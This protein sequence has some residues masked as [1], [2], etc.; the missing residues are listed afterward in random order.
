MLVG[1]SYAT[2]SKYP[3]F[4]RAA[5]AGA[6]SRAAEQLRVAQPALS[7]YIR[8]LEQ[9]VGVLLFERNGRGVS[10][11][12]DGQ[13]LYRFAKSVFDKL[14]AAELEVANPSGPPLTTVKLGIVPSMTEVLAVPLAEAVRQQMPRVGLHVSEGQNSSLLRWLDQGVIDIAVSFYEFRPPHILVETMSE[15]ELFLLGAESRLAGISEITF[16]E[17]T[18]LPL[19]LPPS[20]HPI[21]LRFNSNAIETGHDVNVV[22]ETEAASIAG[23]MAAAE[24]GF[25]PV[26]KAACRG[27][28]ERRLKAVRIVEPVLTQTL[29]TMTSLNRPPSSCERRFYELVR[30]HLDQ[31]GRTMSVAA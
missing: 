13:R 4:I 24:L 12:Q 25:A 27:L 21:R 3:F 17:S 26:P 9:E 29:V 22:L 23:S 14:E 2:I 31:I 10:L 6:I 8:D 1:T 28:A 20:P 11:T 5:E 16:D 18:R 7:R 30:S 19:I 15:Q